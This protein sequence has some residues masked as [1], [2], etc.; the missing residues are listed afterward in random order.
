MKSINK[1]NIFCAYIS[2]P[3]TTR[4]HSDRHYSGYFFLLL[5]SQ[6]RM[7]SVTNDLSIVRLSIRY[8][9]IIP[10]TLL[11]FNNCN[12]GLGAEIL[13]NWVKVSSPPH[14]HFLIIQKIFC[15]NLGDNL[16]LKLGVIIIG[17]FFGIFTIINFISTITTINFHSCNVQLELTIWLIDE[18]LI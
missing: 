11:I 3:L 16:L 5:T 4:R 10:W 17:D 6:S 7:I 8:F 14:L 9:L 15:L 2:C 1:G 18:F 13:S 12:Y